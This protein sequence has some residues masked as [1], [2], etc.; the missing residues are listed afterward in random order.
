MVGSLAQ[1]VS[2]LELI[3]R[4]HPA[5]VVGPGRSRPRPAAVLALISEGADPDL[6]VTERSAT[7]RLHA[8][9]LSFPGGRIDPED[10]NSAAAALREAAE[11]IGLP[12]QAATV[13]G[14][15]PRTRLTR[16]M[17]DVAV[18]VASWNGEA[19][20]GV[21]DRGEVASIQRYRLADLADP[22]HRFSARHPGGGTGPAFVFGEL[23]IWGFTAHLID[24]LLRRGGWEEPWHRGREID[25]PERF[26]RDGPPDR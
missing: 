15:L 20:I 2:Q 11:E 16:T 17:F 24:E 7:L 18:V 19:P 10:L 1:L 25:I 4:S 6:V 22:E 5:S 14:E 13:W 3:G 23:M 12:P 8:G 21:V 9:Q 26:L